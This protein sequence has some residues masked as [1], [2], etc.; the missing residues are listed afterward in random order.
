M[1]YL[2]KCC[3][4]FAEG[5]ERRLESKSWYFQ[6]VSLTRPFAAVCSCFMFQL[7]GKNNLYTGRKSSLN[8]DISNKDLILFVNKKHG[9]KRQYNL[10]YRM[11]LAHNFSIF[12]SCQSFYFHFLCTRNNV[13]SF[14]VEFSVNNI[15]KKF[16]KKILLAFNIYYSNFVNLSLQNIDIKKLRCRDVT[17]T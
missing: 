5:N 10:R 6:S 8:R 17:P 4:I 13:F 12:K 1:K 2:N 14:E 3:Y 15:L 7:N 16:R 9:G 11:W